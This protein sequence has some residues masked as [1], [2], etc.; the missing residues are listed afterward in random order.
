[1]K[2]YLEERPESEFIWKLYKQKLGGTVKIKNYSRYEMLVQKNHSYSIV[3]PNGKKHFIKPDTEVGQKLY[4][5]SCGGELHY[6]GITNRPMSARISVGLKA[7]RKNGYYGYAW[8][9][10]RKPL[11]LHV[12]CWSGKG[13]LQKNIEA[14]EA[15]IAFLCR[16]ITGDWP[17]S[18]TEIHFRPLNASHKKLAFKV[19]IMFNTSNNKKGSRRKSV[20]TRHHS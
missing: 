9:Q 8:K 6:V 12:I 16:T 4:L 13:N 14:I 1:M 11:I 5:V 15:E 7:E 17:L 18:Q 3:A 20:L 10:I 2:Y 19:Y